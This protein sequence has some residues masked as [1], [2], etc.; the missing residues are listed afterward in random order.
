MKANVMATNAGRSMDSNGPRIDSDQ[1]HA[2][3]WLG[4]LAATILALGL[5]YVPNFYS[6][7]SIW[8][9]DPNYSHCWLVIPIALII[10]RQRLTAPGSSPSPATISRPTLGWCFLAAILAMRAFAYE[11]SLQWL[12]TATIPP[13]IACLV[14]S[15]GSWPLL[16]RVWP[17]IA[18]LVFMLPLPGPNP[19]FEPLGAK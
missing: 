2:Q 14:W 10:L 9:V 6:L 18:F 19:T 3:I 4:A 8:L 1:R 5:A 13:T 12:E 7:A 11:R 16:R 15:F 17:A